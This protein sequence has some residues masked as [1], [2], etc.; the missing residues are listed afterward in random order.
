MLRFFDWVDG[1]S[2]S[3]LIGHSDHFGFGFV[4]DLDSC[5]HTLTIKFQL[6]LWTCRLPCVKDRSCVSDEDYTVGDIYTH[7]FS[8][9]SLILQF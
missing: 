1:F 4:T 9:L 7:F 6:V 8:N 5:A 2:V 3:F